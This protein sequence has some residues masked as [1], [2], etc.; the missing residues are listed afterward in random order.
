MK[1]YFHGFGMLFKRFILRQNTG[2]VICD[3]AEK[4]GVVYVKMAQILAMQNYGK[5]FTEND[6]QHLAKICDNCNPISFKKIRQQLEREYGCPLEEKFAEI[7]E[8]PL[9]AA[10]ISQV[11]RATLLDGR[12]VAVK[13]K[14]HDVTRRVQ[15]DVRQIRRMIHRFGRFAYFRNLLGSDKALDLWAKWI[16]SET[17]FRSEQRNLQH[18]REFVATVNGKVKSAANLVVPELYAEYCTENVIV[19]EYVSAPTINQIPLTPE[20]KTRLAKAINDYASLSFY[21]LLHEMPITFHGDPHSGNIYLDEAGNVGFLDLGL[22]FSFTPDEADFVRRLFLCAYNVRTDKLIELLLKDSDYTAFDHSE[23]RAAIEAEIQRFQSIPV[24]Q[25]FVEMIMVYTKYNI[26][27]PEVLFKMAKAFIALYGINNF[28]NNTVDTKELLMGQVIE[29]YV[30]RAAKDLK[31]I[32][33]TGGD[34]LPDVL[35]AVSEQGLSHGI[36]TGIQTIGKLHEEFGQI[37]E[38]CQEILALFRSRN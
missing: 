2:K 10:S 5:I 12:E 1:L 7:S 27:P 26:A 32:I 34:I 22:M 9:G 15:R 35:T 6:R 31:T 8:T 14:R 17:D 21:A 16:E 11:H 3:F 28:I 30:D 19:M 24:T 18:Y 33:H 25:F 36:A 20:N 38:N 23:F 13:I 4:M 37:L 29:Y